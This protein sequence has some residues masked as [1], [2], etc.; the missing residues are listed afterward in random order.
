VNPASALAAAT[1][2]LGRALAEG[3]RDARGAWSRRATAWVLG[4]AALAMAAPLVIPAGRMGTAAAGLY[5]ALA[6]VGLNLAVGLA[7]V[8]SLGQGAFVGIGAFAVALL[9]AR[10]GWSPG[11]ATLAGAG[12]ATVAG[13]LAGWGA[14]R[15]ATA[16]AAVSTWALAWLVSLGLAAFPGLFGGA[17]GVPVGPLPGPDGS[18]PGGQLTALGH[19]E[20]ALALLALCLFV[21]SVLRRGP[22][23]RSLSVAEQAP[24]TA[25][26]LGI[27]PG[28]RRLG[29]FA[30]SALVGGLAGG[31]AV[32]VA[33][34]ADATEYGPLLS[35]ELF[36]AV[37]IGGRG[38]LLGPVAGAA[39]LGLVGP[40]SRALADLT[41]TQADRVEGVIAAALLA[42]ALV[43]GGTGAGGRPGWLRLR[44]RAGGSS[45]GDS[46]DGTD[47]EPTPPRAA[48]GRR[49]PRGAA[50]LEA[51]DLEVRFGGV[52]ALNR[53]SI[54]VRRGE[55]HAVIGPNGSGKTTL[56]RALGG[57]VAANGTIRLGRADLSRAPVRTRV[58]AGL[59]RTL[60]RTAVAPGL[61]VVDHA[62]TGADARRR[63]GPIRALLATPAA[64]AEARAL[65]REVRALLR[66]AGLDADRS[67]PVSALNGEQQ[68]LMAIVTAL[69]ARPRV[70]LLDEPAAGMS[71][72][73]RER[74]VGVL[75]RLRQAGL[76]IVVVEHD[77]RLV[78][79]VADAATVLDAGVVIARGTPAAVA[80]NP[81]VI[82]AY[83]GPEGLGRSR[84]L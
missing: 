80:R 9:T 20:L 57:T 56:L 5:I 50:L 3:S 83:L 16:S 73:G 34:V 72:R 51:E 27:E 67:L 13:L 40:A 2:R 36:V 63:T 30:A 58:R 39:V 22:A 19:L 41:G 4:Y 62:L 70:M 17:R 6:A 24:G 10:A 15:L 29:A 75:L 11:A 14:V 45:G 28:G 52:V 21:T 43:A 37:L 12:A 64:R 18:L 35:V 1:A 54:S 84:D 53:V 78:R 60:Q 44:T 32:Q 25:R 77:V 47:G 33:G 68:R 74:L 66:L 65:E 79:A 48:R 31:L 59:V 38:T 71:A 61:S 7:G 46:G 23:G 55:I 8:P 81:K 49:R 42:V 26:A 69:A 82:R 76:A